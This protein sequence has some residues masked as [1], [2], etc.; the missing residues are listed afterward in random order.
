MPRMDSRSPQPYPFFYCQHF[1]SGIHH[2][3]QPG[4]RSA[5]PGRGERRCVEIHDLCAVV[6]LFNLAVGDQV[7]EGRDGDPALFHVAQG[8]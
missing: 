2:R 7:V 5:G 1:T 6:L 8:E 3:V 4:L